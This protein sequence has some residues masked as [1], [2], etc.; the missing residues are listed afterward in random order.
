V[1]GGGKVANMPL[2]MVRAATSA[3]HRYRLLVFAHPQNTTGLENAI[4]GGVDVLAHTAPDSP[5]W[6]PE[7]VERLRRAHMALIPTLTLFDFEARKG[8]ESDAEREQWITKM[9]EELRAFSQSGGQVL[10][11]TDVGYTDHYDT[12]LEYE[13][14]ARAG[15][16]FPQILASLTTTPARRF[17]AVHKGRVAKGT[18]ADLVILDADPSEDITAL[19]RV[20]LTIRA[21]KITYARDK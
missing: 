5:P 6:T 18:D 4:E 20:D 19:A 13:L 1:Q 17:H 15:M 10:F 14:M 7:F 8:G 2:D 3:A 16:T 21:G 9:V 12:T 11:G